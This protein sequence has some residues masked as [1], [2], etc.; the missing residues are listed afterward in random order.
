MSLSIIIFLSLTSPDPPPTLNISISYPTGLA[1][2]SQPVSMH[3]PLPV[4]SLMTKT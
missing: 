1:A 4:E 2:F 3:I